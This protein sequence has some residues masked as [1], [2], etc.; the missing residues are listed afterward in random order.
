MCSSRKNNLKNKSFDLVINGLSRNIAYNNDIIPLHLIS[1]NTFFYDMNYSLENTC[2]LN[3]CMKL[4]GKHVSDGIGMLVFQA[5][6]SF[7]EWHGVFPK[8][9]YIISMLSSK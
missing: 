7:L 3:W 8:T 9:D 2:F 6:Y 1:S 5:A 4:G